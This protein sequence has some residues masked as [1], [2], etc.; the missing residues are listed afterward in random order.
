MPISDQKISKFPVIA[1][2]SIVETYAL[3]SRRDLEATIMLNAL[4]LYYP[5]MTN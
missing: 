2:Y 5:L 1:L 4:T 3:S